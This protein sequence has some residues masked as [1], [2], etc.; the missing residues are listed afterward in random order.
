MKKIGLVVIMIVLLA[1]VANAA[2]VNGDFKGNPIVK[3]KANGKELTV[4]NTPAVIYNGNT[5]VPIYMLRQLGA[6]VTWDQTTYSVDV[7]IDKSNDSVGILKDHSVIMDIY[8]SLGMFGDRTNEIREMLSIISQ[9]I[10]NDN[11]DI[12]TVDSLKNV[13]EYLNGLYNEYNTM[14][15]DIRSSMIASKYITNFEIEIISGVLE[16]YVKILE[17]YGLM[18]FNLAEY[19]LDKNI[20]KYTEYTNNYI[21]AISMVDDAKSESNSGYNYYYTLIQDY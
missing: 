18:M 17:Q 16:Q 10:D 4:E 5:L 20:Q 2:S 14:N 1:T 19:A 12:R 7:V 11:R 8:R 6:E 21:K 15:T 13:K 9:L 3:V